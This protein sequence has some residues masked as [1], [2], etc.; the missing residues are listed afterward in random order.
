M[1]ENIETVVFETKEDENQILVS[2]KIT[3]VSEEYQQRGAVCTKLLFLL[4]QI[5]FRIS[6]SV[7]ESFKVRLLHVSIIIVK[8]QGLIL[9]IMAH[10][11]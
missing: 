1:F 6:V 3:G 5:V 8:Q 10:Y 4:M 7:N 2:G 11:I 9:R